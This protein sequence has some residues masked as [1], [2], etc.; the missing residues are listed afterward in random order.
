MMAARHGRAWIIALWLLVGNVMGGMLMYG[1]GAFLLEP[2]AEPL[3]QLLGVEEEY[4][5]AS[6]DLEENA[7]ETLFLVGVTPF[8]YQVGTAA[9]GA[10]G[11][12]LPVFLA[13]VSLS[14]GIRYMALAGLVMV[15]GSRARNFIERHE[16]EIFIAGIVTFVLLGAWIFWKG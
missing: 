3:F 13:A 1:A 5:Q 7:F 14:R 2:V 10:A 4:E 6:A 15:I 9:A 11:V 16:L 12:S 8:P